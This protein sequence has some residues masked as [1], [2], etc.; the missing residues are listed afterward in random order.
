MYFFLKRTF[1]LFFLIAFSSFA[2]DDFKPI[3]VADIT[4]KG[5]FR[6]ESVY[7]LRS[8]NDGEHY[9]TSKQG[10]LILMYA[11]KTGEVTDTLFNIEKPE[12]APFEHFSDYMFS[13]SED[14]ILFET[15][16][17]KIY[18]RS[19]R[20]EFYIYNRRQKTFHRLSEGGKQR[21]ATFL[22]D[23]R[24][25]TFVRKNNLFHVDMDS[26][27]E[28]QVTHDGKYNHIINGTTDGY[29][30]KSLRSPKALPGPLTA[31]NWPIP[32]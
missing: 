2:S 22:P 17:E 30:K 20:A 31:K 15:D 19:Y 9:T 5:T 7:G 25:I 26:G 28:V 6:S 12:K 1:P 11:Y 24:K 4:D 3:S 8:M 10:R 23:G 27:Q 32:L 16:H 29:M 21:L 18:R 13:P 14:L